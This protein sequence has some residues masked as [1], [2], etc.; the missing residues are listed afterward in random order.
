M[1]LERF[2]ALVLKLVDN[3]F[4]VREIPLCF[5]LSMKLQVNETKGDR[6]FNMTF[7]E[8]LEAY[9]RVIDK[10]SPV[11][12]GD[13]TANWTSEDRQN[14]PLNTKI[15]NVMWTF[16]KCISHPDYKYLKD[17][18]IH[19]MK[20]EIGLFKFDNANPHYAHIWP[21]KNLLILV[22]VAMK[23]KVMGSQKVSSTNKLKY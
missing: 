1:D 18:F 20:D 10:Y 14:Q 16:I 6:I 12:Y 15:E 5:N 11:P 4:P 21:G 19:P 22:R 13:M 17:K 3:E 8:F 9:A 7:S 2:T 23:K